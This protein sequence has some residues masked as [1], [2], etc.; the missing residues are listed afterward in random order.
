MAHYLKAVAPFVHLIR[1]KQVI[2]SPALAVL[3]TYGSNTTTGEI[4]TFECVV[5]TEQNELTNE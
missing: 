2:K 4:H 3:A 1:N 5:R